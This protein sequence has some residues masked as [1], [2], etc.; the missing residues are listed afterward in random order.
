MRYGKTVN[1]SSTTTVDYYTKSIFREKEPTTLADIVTTNHTGDEVTVADDLVGVKVV[2]VFDSNK[3]FQKFLLYAKDY[4]KY[5]NPGTKGQ[6]QRD[7]MASSGVFAGPYDQSNWVALDFGAVSDSPDDLA[8][9]VDHVIAGGTIKGTYVDELNPTIRLSALPEHGVEA[10]Y[11]PNLY[12]VPS[13]CDAYAAEG[14]AYFFV[15]PK[16]QEYCVVQWAN[17]D[18]A[19]DAFY[20]PAK[21]DD[22][23][24]WDLSGGFD[25]DASYLGPQFPAPQ[26]KLMY[27]FP[28]IVQMKAATE[29]GPRRVA[30][31][32][33]KV[34]GLSARYTVLPLE[35]DDTSVITDITR[36]HSDREVADDGYYYTLT[37]QR[38][39]HPTPGFYIRAGKKVFIS[40]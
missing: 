7:Y 4:N 33:P 18:A 40:H 2:S 10:T 16:P 3:D 38:V 35:M 37:G 20:V 15:Q 24:G 23:N 30:T 21:E 5:A 31:A 29:R 12:V 11:S 26:D 14:S 22:N 1:G 8:N 36:V 25:W 17:Y 32:N 27:T 9:L 13:F 28:A 6:N 34:G 39:A 19:T